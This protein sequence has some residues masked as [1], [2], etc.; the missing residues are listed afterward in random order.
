MEK[1]IYKG[2]KEKGLVIFYPIGCTNLSAVEKRISIL[3]GESIELVKEDA[4]KLIQL[5]PTNFEIKGTEIISP[6]E[7]KKRVKKIK[8]VEVA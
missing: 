6:K 3:P 5:D 2:K 4:E 1:V 7:P 8:E